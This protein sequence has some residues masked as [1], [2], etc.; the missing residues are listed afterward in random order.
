MTTLPGWR[1]ADNDT[2]AE[3]IDA[4]K[5]Y[6][7]EQS[8]EPEKWLSS[9]LVVNYPLDYSGYRALRLV[10][11]EA[12]DFVSALSADVWS[13][14]AAVILAGY[15]LK[16]SHSG[17][18]LLTT[19]YTKALDETVEALLGLIS[20]Q[21]HMLV[22]KLLADLWDPK[23][24]Q[25]LLRKSSD[26]HLHADSL[27]ELFRCLFIHK[28]KAA[29]D[30]ASGLVGLCG[31][32]DEIDRARAVVAGQSLLLYAPDKSWATVWPVV[33]E[34][35]VFGTEVV[36]KVIDM[37]GWDRESNGIRMAD[38]RLADF[39]I[40]VVHHYPYEED[41]VIQGFIGNRARVAMWKGDALGVLKNRG[42]HQA[43]ERI[44]QEFP[45]ID[46]LRCILAESRTTACYDS[47]VPLK[48]EDILKL[49]RNERYRVIRSGRELLEAIEESLQRLQ[50][51]LH[52]ETPA[53]VFLWDHV[54]IKKRLYKPK[55]E[56][57][58]SDFVQIHLADDLRPKG[59]IPYRE[60]RIRP[61]IGSTRG[62]RT[63]IQVSVSTR[64]KQGNPSDTVTVIIEV[65]G[66]WNKDLNKAMQT[67][68]ADRYLKD[69]S[70]QHG[71]YLVAW[72]ESDCWMAEDQRRK[73]KPK[74]TFVEA[75][76][77]FCEQAAQLSRDGREIRAYVMDASLQ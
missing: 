55:D 67:Q 15:D 74:T 31:S 68:L 75:K 4:A 44:A 33:Q 13:R 66:C 39:Y 63:D 72:F 56:N 10:E 47:W 71:L 45:D 29:I 21:R 58:F 57:A 30:Y 3:I 54:K 36:E 42:A 5:R 20:R 70:C 76:R 40:W 41:P 23:I 34:D 35:K 18:K 51:K 12:P 61:A 14:W 53:V 1:A 7:L 6:L 22:T 49:A 8:P 17:L 69:N 52:D 50:T 26:R 62:E 38:E 28:D 48:P 73:C 46:W 19:A 77:Q 2:K 59:I 11:K 27:R 60:V 9:D 64:D 32:S 43:M 16:Q 37:W 25:A 65:K 24:A